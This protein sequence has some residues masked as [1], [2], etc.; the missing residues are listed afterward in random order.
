MHLFIKKAVSLTDQMAYHCLFFMD[1]KQ[2][3]IFLDLGRGDVILQSI[4]DAVKN[5]STHTYKKNSRLNVNFENRP[6][7][8]S[9]K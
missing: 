5:K 2:Q 9:L 1:C 4:F 6:K 8:N 3:V 7:V